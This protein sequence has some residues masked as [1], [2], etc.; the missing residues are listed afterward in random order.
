MD[1]GCDNVV[2]LLVKGRANVAEVTVPL[3]MSGRAY[4]LDFG[5]DV[6]DVLIDDVG[7]RLLDGK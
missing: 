2:V 1:I 4:L 3:V 7:L 6:D 5:A